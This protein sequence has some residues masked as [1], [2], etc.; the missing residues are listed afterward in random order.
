MKEYQVENERALSDPEKYVTNPFSSFSL[1]RRLGSDWKHLIKY[2]KTDVGDEFLTKLKDYTMQSNFPTSEDVSEA[3][4]GIVRIQ[5]T[6][7]LNPKDSIKGLI[8][9][10]Q[11]K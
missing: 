9:G 5:G 3:V 2:L 10:V 8:N 4:K 7:K 11:Y 1:I 6:Y